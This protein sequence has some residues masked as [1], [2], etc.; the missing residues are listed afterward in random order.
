MS[1][2]EKAMRA[3][4]IRKGLNP[5]KLAEKLGITRQGVYEIMKSHGVSS[6]H[7][8]EVCRILDVPAEI[9]LPGYVHKMDKQEDK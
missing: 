5:T 6:P 8:G 7:L 2:R 9:F 3:A 4:M 1:E